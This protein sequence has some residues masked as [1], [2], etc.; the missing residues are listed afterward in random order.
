[1]FRLFVAITAA[2]LSAGAAFAGCAPVEFEGFS[3]TVCRFDLR[4]ERLELFNLDAEGRPFGSFDALAESL[5][6]EGKAL[7]FAMNGGMYDDNQK[8]IGLYVEDGKEAKAVNRRNGAGNFHLKPN[9]VFYIK[10][11]RAGVAD[12]ETYLRLKARPDYA[13]QSG[14]ML[15]INGR[16][17]PAFSPD[18][19]SYRGLRHLRGFRPLL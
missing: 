7:A 19:T 1:M 11:R 8:P 3:Y 6:S 13:T 14:P 18:G 9:G 10:G 17:H 15:V 2:F 4:K 5:G 12:T 16:I